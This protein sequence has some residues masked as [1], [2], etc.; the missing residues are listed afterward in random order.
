[1]MLQIGKYGQG[2]KA[3]LHKIIILIIPVRVRFFR[4]C[5]HVFLTR[6]NLLIKNISVISEQGCKNLL[7]RSHFANKF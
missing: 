1:M 7:N 4:R 5:F 6:K 3:N 2:L